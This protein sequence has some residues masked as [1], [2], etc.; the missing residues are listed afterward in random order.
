MTKQ[1][2]HTTFQITIEPPLPSFRILEDIAKKLNLFAS[3]GSLENVSNGL[4]VNPLNYVLNRRLTIGVYLRRNQI[5]RGTKAYASL[6]KKLYEKMF[7][8]QSTDG[9]WDRKKQDTKTFLV[10]DALKNADFMKQ[11]RDYCV[12]TEMKYNT[13]VFVARVLLTGKKFFL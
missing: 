8:D 4:K 2:L 11:K 13:A 5:K 9:S 3:C 7:A 6:K 12:A 10:L 1:L